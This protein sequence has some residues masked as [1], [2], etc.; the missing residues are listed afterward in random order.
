M[1]TDRRRPRYRDPKKRRFYV[2]PRNRPSPG[3]GRSSDLL[4]IV[5]RRDEERI[6]LTRVPVETRAEAS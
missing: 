6:D 4:L 3:R 1:F 2:L 5:Y